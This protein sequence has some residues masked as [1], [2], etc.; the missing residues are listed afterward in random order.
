MFKCIFV[1]KKRGI[2]EIIAKSKVEEALIQKDYLGWI[3][4]NLA[5]LVSQYYG[6]PSKACS[7]HTETLKAM[8][9]HLQTALGISEIFID[10]QH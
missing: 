2:Q 1:V 6:M 8:E 10:I 5:M 4:C 9:F 7:T 3:I